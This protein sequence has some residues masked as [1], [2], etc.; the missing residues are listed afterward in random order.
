LA[1]VKFSQYFQQIF[2]KPLDETKCETKKDNEQVS[3]QDSIKTENIVGHDN[4]N[5]QVL[6]EGIDSMFIVVDFPF[7]DEEKKEGSWGLDFDGA[8]SSTG[9]GAGIVLSPPVC[10]GSPNCCP[11]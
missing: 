2:V 11:P 5:H 8:H 1:E 6:K 4:V 9:S 3:L 7:I 10:P